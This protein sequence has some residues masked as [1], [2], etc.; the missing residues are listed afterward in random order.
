MPVVTTADAE[1]DDEDDDEDDVLG[2]LPGIEPEPGPVPGAEEELAVGNGVVPLCGVRWFDKAM[3]V[4]ERAEGVSALLEFKFEIRRCTG[5][6][7]TKT[8][9]IVYATI[10]IITHVNTIRNDFF[11]K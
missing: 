11:I 8:I 1:P 4:V 3:D 9:M 6:C 7:C 10:R 2:L 5:G